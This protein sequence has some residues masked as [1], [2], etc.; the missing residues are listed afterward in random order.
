MTL[1]SVLAS[2][3]LPLHYVVFL[4]SYSMCLLAGFPLFSWP[5]I[6]VVC[7]LTCALVRADGS[8]ASF[9]Q[10]SCIAP[11]LLCAWP[12]FSVWRIP[13]GMFGLR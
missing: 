8:V 1:L 10:T 5:L 7:L 12:F 4:P 6:S 13:T 3:Q 9:L 2:A 11:I